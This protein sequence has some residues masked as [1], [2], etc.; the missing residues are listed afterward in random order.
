MGSSH[1]CGLLGGEENL[2]LCLFDLAKENEQNI[3]NISKLTK[4]SA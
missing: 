3:L 1:R 2:S 4:V